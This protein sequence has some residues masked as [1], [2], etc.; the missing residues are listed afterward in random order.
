MINGMIQCKEREREEDN[1]II[2]E[3]NII[4]DEKM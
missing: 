2:P 1:I 3:Y 4:I